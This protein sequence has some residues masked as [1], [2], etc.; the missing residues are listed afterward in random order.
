[1]DMKKIAQ[2]IDELGFSIIESVVDAE[3]VI[4]L[5]KQLKAA[6]E[7]DVKEYGH[8]PAKKVNLIVDLTTRGSAFVKLLENEKMQQG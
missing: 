6:L 8:L 3:E 1:M 4:L 5:K 7:E 2:E